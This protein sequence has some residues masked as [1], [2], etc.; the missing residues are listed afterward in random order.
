MRTRIYGPNSQ[1]V[2]AMIERWERLSVA[3]LVC[4]YYAEHRDIWIRPTGIGGDEGFFRDFQ[5]DFLA[6]DDENEWQPPDDILD[7]NCYETAEVLC[8]PEDLC[9]RADD[10]GDGDGWDC[11]DD[12]NYRLFAIN[13]RR[14]N[15]WDALTQARDAAI[16]TGRRPMMAAAIGNIIRTMPDDAQAH[17]VTH[18]RE[19]LKSATLDSL[20]NLAR[21]CAGGAAIDAALALVTWDLAGDHSLYSQDMRDLLYKPWNEIVELAGLFC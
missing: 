18:G 5:V 11:V 17:L 15:R 7:D 13:D 6:G 20:A 10:S 1:A 2:K 16:R 21:F 4:L 8:G 3:E 9:A 12:E 19:W 14:R